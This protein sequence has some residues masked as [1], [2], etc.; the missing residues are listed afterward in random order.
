MSRKESEE[1]FLHTLETLLK[2]GSDLGVN[3][4]AEKSGLNKVLI[5]RYFGGWDG[6]LEAYAKR[7]NLWRSIR[8]DL[9]SGLEKRH[10]QSW[11]ETTFWVFKT[12]RIRLV[13]SPVYLRILKEEMKNPNPLTRKLEVEREEEGLN[14]SHL[15]AR[16]FPVLEKNDVLAAG[17]FVMSGI[18]YLV[19][20][21]TEVDTFNGLDMRDEK[22]WERIDEIWKR[23]FLAN[24][25]RH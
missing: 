17:A 6:L 14:I 9:E 20:K 11:Q 19:L 24:F 10:W 15:I 2:E 1:R 8:E 21:A 12:Y 13:E 18:T 25:Q 22:S 7:I 16:F 23:T 3:I 5:Y 4:L